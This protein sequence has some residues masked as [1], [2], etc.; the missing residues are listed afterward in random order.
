MTEENRKMQAYVRAGERKAFEL[1]NRGPLR[2]N[3]DGTPA[4]EILDAYWRCGFYV[5]EGALG[6]EELEE[7]QSDMENAL[8]RAPY[9]RDAT[10]DA[11][12]RPA[13]GHDLAESTFRFAKPLS[14]PFGSTQLV[15]G[16][17]PAKMYEPP[18]PDNAPDFVISSIAH[19]LQIMD[20]CLRLYGHPQ[21]L[22]IAEQVN[23]SDFTPFTESVIVKP[24]GLGPSVAWHRDGTTHWDSPALDEGTHGFNFMAQLYGSTAEN[25]VWVL[26]GSHKLRELDIKAM[27]E[28]NGSDR[29]QGAVPMVCA[30]GDVVISNRQ[31][32]HASFANTSPQKRVTINFGFHRRRSVLNVRTLH[33]GKEVCFDDHRIHERSRVIALAID[34]RR[35]RFPHETRYQYEPMAGE[36]ES[37]RWSDATRATVLLNYNLRNL[38][39]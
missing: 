18:P 37:N 10:V 20:A 9:T 21:L 35:Q 30:P 26:P 5:F 32:L 15:N 39:I 34:A 27:V 1:G 3:P 17:H 23:G 28:D 12:G 6:V 16:R 38:G 31:A 24:A 19:P 36:E 2:F 22:R 29:L 33:N 25:G 14:D 13:L 8:E 4:Q 7:L 11:Q